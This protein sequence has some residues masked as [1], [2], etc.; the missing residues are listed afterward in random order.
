MVDYWPPSAQSIFARSETNNYLNNI[1]RQNCHQLAQIYIENHHGTSGL[2]QE[3]IA[4]REMRLA[5]L[6]FLLFQNEVMENDDFVYG[7]VIINHLVDIGYE[8]I[9][10]RKLANLVISPLRD[11]GVII[12]SGS[13]GYRIPTT[14]DDIIEFAKTTSEKVVPMIIRLGRAR[15]QICVASDGQLD[16]VEESGNHIVNEFI[17]VQREPSTGG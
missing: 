2:D 11:S 4:E 8:E 15:D 1:I 6:R 16:I 5:V 13:R 9:S 12:S 7:K 3:E 17:R 14:V 10:L